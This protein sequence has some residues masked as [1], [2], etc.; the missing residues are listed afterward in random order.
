MS[1][2]IHTQGELLQFSTHRSNYY[3]T[4]A[5]SFVFVTMSSLANERQVYLGVWALQ[6]IQ[7]A[8]G[9]SLMLAKALHSMNPLRLV[10]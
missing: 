10:R 4:K 6:A 2:G 5:N 9:G 7:I 1:Y 8:G 3:I